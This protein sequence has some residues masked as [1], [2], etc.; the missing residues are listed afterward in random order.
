MEEI[1]LCIGTTN[2]AKIEGITSAF[3][4]YYRLRAVITRKVDTGLP[5]QPI[6]LDVIIDGARKRALGAITSE[7]D[8]SVGL[9]AG[10]YFIGEEPYDVE[11]SYIVSREGRES[12][13]LSPSFPIPRAF[14]KW[15]REGTFGELEEIVDVIYGTRNIGD[16]GGFISLLTKGVVLRKELSRYAT[17]MAL[18]K[19]LNQELYAEGTNLAK[20]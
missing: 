14:V 6:G 17:L 15:I 4:A 8:Y 18:T 12:M 13:G 19:L 5:P 9:E 2:P 20:L 11:I 1:A 16:S 10:F 7:C 3:S